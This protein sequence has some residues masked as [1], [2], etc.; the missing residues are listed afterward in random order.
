MRGVDVVVG[1]RGARDVAQLLLGGMGDRWR[2]TMAVAHRA[3][4][5]VPTI[6]ADD[7]D[8][9]LAAAWLHDIGYAEPLRDSGFHPLDG[10]A[11]LDRHGWPRRIS[12]LVAHH[13]GACHVARAVGVDQALAAYPMECSPLADALTYA[14]Q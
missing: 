4:E 2:H 8:V 14:D 11:Y 9:L 7:P 1:V 6:G 12:A 3:E 10:A 13:S 5:L